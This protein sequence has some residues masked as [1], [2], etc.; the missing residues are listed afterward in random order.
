VRN[1]S[2]AAARLGASLGIAANGKSSAIGA[3]SG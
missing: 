1:C 2:A 3:G